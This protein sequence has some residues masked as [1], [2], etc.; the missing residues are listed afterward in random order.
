MPR[1]QRVD[2]AFADL[3]EGERMLI[4]TPALLD[5]LVREIPPGRTKTAKQ[6]RAELAGS[7]DADGTCPLTTG[8]F[9]RIAAEAAWERHLAGTPLDEIMPF[10][11]AIEPE[12]PLAKKLAC[13]I[14]FLRRQRAAE[15]ESA[16]PRRR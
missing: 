9:L 16:T 5:A 1:V 13:G 3:A 4:A 14:D 2:R 15:A 7:H 8:I 10:W 11:R 12:S 6:F